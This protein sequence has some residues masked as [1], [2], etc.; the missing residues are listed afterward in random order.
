[1][2][3]STLP[4]P[5]LALALGFVLAG[6]GRS[7]PAGDTPAGTPLAKLELRLAAEQA[8]KH[9]GAAAAGGFLDE[10]GY[11]AALA[12]QFTLM[13]AENALKFPFVHPAPGI[14]DFSE[15]DALAAF[16]RAHGLKMRGHVLIWRED[17]E[18]WLGA[19]P[20]REAALALM[21]EHIHTVL[22]HYR[23]NFPDVFVHWD[24]VNEAFRA[25]GTLRDSGWHRAIG[26]DFIEHAF[27][28]AHE[29]WP[30][31]TLYY[32]DFEELVFNSFGS[33]IDASGAI[34][35][36]G[37]RPGIG[38]SVVAA[39]CAVSAKCIAIRA[40]ARDFLAR[41]VPIHGIGFQGHIAN[42][43]APDFGVHARWVGELGLEWAVTEL[44]APCAPPA[45]D[46]FNPLLCYQT[47]AQIY[48]SVVGA[49][50]ADPACSGVVQW[51]VA[52]P[53]SWWPGLTGGLLGNPLT[54]DAD[55]ALKP[56]GHAVLEVLARPP[57]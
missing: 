28:Y 52:D 24:V 38:P 6:C 51:G 34:D 55:F 22:G 43:V 3:K 8:G 31:M 56:A 54:L 15:G 11:A 13:T 20:T 53:Y 18:P 29:A 44:D 50:R 45:L 7:T 27:R 14:Y 10:P 12:G 21:R 49:C 48:A 47:Q 36:D 19:N 33:L 30:E 42:L 57:P 17:L 23:R 9:W 4:L 37:L 39:D 16:A 26:D 46:R 1:M 2:N 25:D 35:P 41:G 5:H 40:M 32:N